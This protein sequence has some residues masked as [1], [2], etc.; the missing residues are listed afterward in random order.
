[1]IDE[2]HQLD[3]LARWAHISHV[4]A[5]ILTASARVLDCDYRGQSFLKVGNV[6]HSL[7]GN[8]Y[9]TDPG[10]QLRFNSALK[11][12]AGAGRTANILLHPP[13][14]P[15]KRFS[16]T[17]TRLENGLEKAPPASR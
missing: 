16:L 11:E 1:M 7:D 14:Q 9:C 15:D 12:T 13:R 2:T 4:A 3:H 8:L 6:L 17:L 5:I 10:C